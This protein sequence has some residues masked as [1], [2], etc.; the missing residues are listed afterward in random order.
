MRISPNNIFVRIVISYVRDS[1]CSYDKTEIY[2]LA[3]VSI[4]A[5]FYPFGE[6][7]VMANIIFSSRQQYQQIKN[8]TKETIECNQCFQ[9]LSKEC[10]Y[11]ES[12]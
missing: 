7:E 8:N 3:Q 5:N 12:V 1:S 2:S 10:L 11:A 9:I 4:G 6:Y